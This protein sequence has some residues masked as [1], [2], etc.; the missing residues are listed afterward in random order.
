MREKVDDATRRTEEEELGGSSDLSLQ[1]PQGQW[2]HRGSATGH[3]RSCP[4]MRT[5]YSEHRHAMPSY[6]SACG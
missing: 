5:K 6:P 4:F 3:T 1:G 2:G